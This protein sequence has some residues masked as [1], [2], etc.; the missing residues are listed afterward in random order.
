MTIRGGRSR[1]TNVIT[2]MASWT[3]LARATQGTVERGP[4]HFAARSPQEVYNNA[5]LLDA[6]S[7]TLEALDHFYE[8]SQRWALW[9]PDRRTDDLARS[10]GLV[11]AEGTTDMARP[12]D[13]LSLDGDPEAGVEPVD[14]S[15]VAALNG[16]PP[17]VVDGARGFIG[18]AVPGRAGVLLFRHEDDVQLSFLSTAPAHRR[19]GFGRSVV[20]A[21]LAHARTDGAR[22]A[23]LQSTPAAVSLYRRAGFAVVGR[24]AEW[25]PPDARV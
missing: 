11:E 22:T 3:E 17:D 13:D 23:S 2:L 1:A 25:T 10:A 20:M 8:R 19:R 12:L 18:L 9:S 4:G 24:W 7:A 5:L 14:V 6:D 16:L 21:A 15:A